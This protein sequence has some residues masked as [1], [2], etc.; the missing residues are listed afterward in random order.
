[1]GDRPAV[2]DPL[3]FIQQCVTARGIYWSHHV[4]MRMRNRAITRRMIL[5]TVDSYTIIESNP[6][7]KYLPTYL[8]LARSG[9]NAFHIL[10]ALDTAEKN[11]RVVT[12]YWPDPGRWHDNYETRKN[13]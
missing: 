8:V 4:N 10:F 6:G 12:A 5:D 2:E 7:D 9:E 3:A 1:M 13:R 11:V